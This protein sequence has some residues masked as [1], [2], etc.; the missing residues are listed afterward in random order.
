MKKSTVASEQ[1]ERARPLQTLKSLVALLLASAATAAPQDASIATRVAGGDYPLNLI[2]VAERYLV[3][4]NNG[5]GKHYLQAYDETRRDVTAKL[6]LPSLWF[7]LAYERHSKRL[8]ASD[9]QNGVQVVPFESG[10]FGS[11]KSVEVSGCK[12]TA[13]LLLPDPETALVAC[14]QSH[15][16]VRFN[17]DTGAVLGRLRVGEFPLA[18]QM[19]DG[20]RM[21]VSNWG[22]SS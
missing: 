22:E 5:Y 9:G 8:V 15:E 11:P 18:L 13:G 17:L 2:E 21:A 7:G 20:N 14:N 4:T 6:E 1:A 10:L 16:V 12:L 19:L 3:S